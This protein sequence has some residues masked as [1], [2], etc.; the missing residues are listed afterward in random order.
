MRSIYKYEKKKGYLEYAYLFGML[1]MT[2]GYAMNKYVGWFAL[3]LLFCLSGLAVVMRFSNISVDKNT[4]VVFLIMILNILVTFLYNKESK[5]FFINF[6]QILL[7]FLFVS[8]VSFQN[9]VQKFT[10]LMYFLAAYSLIVYLIALLIPQVLTFFPITYNI[11]RLPAYN[12]GFSV[13]VQ[14]SNML[15]NN[16]F[17]WEPGAYQ[18][19]L[20]LALIF[21]L[22]TKYKIEWKSIFVI[23]FA[24]VT[25]YST[26]GYICAGLIYIVYMWQRLFERQEKNNKKLKLIFIF[27]ILFTG[28]VIT[29]SIL[30]NYVQHQLFGKVSIYFSDSDSIYATSSSVRF[31]AVKYAVEAFKKS[32]YIG[33]G[34]EGFQA[35]IEQITGRNVITCTPLNWFAVYGVVMGI[36]CNWGFFLLLIKK[37]FSNGKMVS[38]LLWCIVILLLSS[39]DYSRNPTILLFVFYG[40]Q[41]QK[42]GK[43]RI[44]ELLEFPEVQSV[45]VQS[46]KENSEDDIEVVCSQ[47]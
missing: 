47:N 29:Y 18:T 1:Y 10:K 15:R 44:Q 24:I 4:A 27:T 5:N 22:F 26:T 3:T 28:A 33:L 17:F 39:E 9:F 42:K 8:I 19:F 20:N 13:V 43:L 23:T 12:L 41:V 46:S 25:T 7:A 37:Y 21:L 34:R 32:P 6:A 36:L 14:E 16:G 30:P 35:Y 38:I 40:Y 2:C 31:D 45:I 11:Q